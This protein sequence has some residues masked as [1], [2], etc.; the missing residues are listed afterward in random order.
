MRN[1]TYEG[2]WVRVR[3]FP[4]YRKMEE[5]DNLKMAITTEDQKQQL[6]LIPGNC[7]GNREQDAAIGIDI[8]YYWKTKWEMIITGNCD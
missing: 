7:N 2:E 8:T 5:N 1:Q 4:K 6:I 3:K